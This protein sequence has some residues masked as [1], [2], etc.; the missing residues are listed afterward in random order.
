MK[1]IFVVIPT[2]NESEN[3]VKTISAILKVFDTIKNYNMNILVVD[4]N[5]PDK[6]YDL[7]VDN[8]KNKNVFALKEK[9]KRGIGY[10]Y[11][12]S[13][14][15]AFNEYNADAVIT[16]DADLSH[17]HNKIPIFIK[18][19]DKGANIVVGTRYKEGGGIPDEWGWHRKML[20][21]IGNK[22]VSLIFWEY[23]LSD[24]TSGFKLLSKKLYSEIKNKIKKQNGYTFS[25][26]GSLESLKL[27]YDIVEVPYHFKE[28]VHGK[29]KIGI[30][31]IFNGLY[32][33]LH[34]RAVLL[35]R[36][37]FG[38]VIIA[39]GLGGVTQILTYTF[40][41]KY[42]F[43]ELNILSQP[44]IYDLG[45]GHFYPRLLVA[46]AFSIECGVFMSFYVNNS[47]AFAEKRL[48]GFMF[49]RRYA[50]NHLVVAGAIIIQLFIVQTLSYMFGRGAFYDIIYQILGILVGLIWNFYFYKRIIWKVSKSD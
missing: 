31:Y 15:K 7:V 1:K 38:K 42:L 34:S 8:F 28:R 40:I 43:E 37:R 44:Y 25:I 27:G 24:Y 33:I 20:S 41:F 11:N 45:P 49:F 48:S 50:K 39:G 35:L 26:S 46:Q 36:S 12:Y 9:S 29:S 10:A 21:I 32:Y 47:W 30:E 6:T 14:D 3:I 5:S 13:M 23:N 4:A 2:Y 16:F 22:L 17:D 19:F 18:E